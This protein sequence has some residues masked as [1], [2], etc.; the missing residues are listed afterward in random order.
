VD[1]GVTGG[2][3]YSATYGGKVVLGAVHITQ[4]EGLHLCSS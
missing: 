4:M 2:Y 3:K 1:L